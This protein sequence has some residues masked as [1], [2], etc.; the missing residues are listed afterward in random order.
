MALDKAQ[1]VLIAILHQGNVR[2]EM[3]TAVSQMVLDRRYKK[4]IVTRSHKPI[5]QNR[6]KIVNEFLEGEYDYLLMIDSDNPPL[7]NPLGLIESDKD[8][9]GLPTPQWN[10]G[11]I[12]WVVGDQDESGKFKT[13]LP[14]E[15]WEQV[16]GVGTGCILIKREVLERIPRPFER[17]WK[18]DG[19]SSLGMDWYF[20]EKALKEGFEIWVNWEYR[21]D[22]FKE[23]SLLDIGNSFVQW[24]SETEM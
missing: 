8:I 7:R 11:K 16:G 2:A 17:K 20:C 9:I 10:N 15:G 23:L 1:K 22:H 5:Q 24:H 13:R 14:K 6:H 18:E 3:L 21:C 12:I 19:T 4:T